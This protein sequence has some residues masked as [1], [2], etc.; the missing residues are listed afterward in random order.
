[1]KDLARKE[2][3]KMM[4]YVPGKPIDDVKREYG[5]DKVVKL[6][7]NENPIGAS[8]KVKA[9]ISEALDTIH[10]YP[11]GYVYNLREKLAEKFNVEMNRL[12]FGDGT[13]EIIELLFKAFVNK[14][15]EIIFAE[16]TFVEYER[17]TL[18]MGGKSVKIPMGLGLRH[19]MDAIAA[20]I[21]VNTKMI[22]IC[23]PNNPTG[24]IVSKNEVDEF[25]SKIPDN[26]FVVFDEAY[27]EYAVD[28]KD[29]PNSMYYQKKGYK[30]VITLRTFSKAFGL[31]GLR[32]GYG[33]A[34]L[35][36]IEM[37]EKV[38][39]PFNVGNLAQAGAIAAINDIE[40]MRKSVAINKE[41]KEYLYEEFDKL[42]FTYPKTYANF[43]Y[44]DTGINGKELFEKLLKKGVIVRAMPGSAIRITIGT[45]EENRF[46]IEK[47]KEVLGK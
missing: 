27:F 23:N 45:M 47:L 11:D 5:I 37:L 1:M 32:I 26:I 20:A 42:G 2:I 17:N 34:D 41:G 22:F 8:V 40:H 33:I 10:L 9:A 44:V 39:L 3:L 15:D 4:P 13:D 21:N 30:N 28:D 25:L 19:D 16:Q 38:R 18:L 31:A 6:A 14:D 35:E 46:F 36:V 7:S 43:I 29:Y 24:T 12:I